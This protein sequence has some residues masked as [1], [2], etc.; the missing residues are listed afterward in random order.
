MSVTVASNCFAVQFEVFDLNDTFR[1]FVEPQA[2]WSCDSI[3]HL[4]VL[5]FRSTKC[6]S[7]SASGAC[8]VRSRW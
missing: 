2:G 4:A 7:V 3:S 8:L 6:R 5:Q 1:L